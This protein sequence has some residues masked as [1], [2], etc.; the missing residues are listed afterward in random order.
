MALSLEGKATEG[1]GGGYTEWIISVV[2][3][4]IAKSLEKLFHYLSLSCYGFIFFSLNLYCISITEWPPENVFIN[5]E[6]VQGLF[7]IYLFHTASESHLVWQLVNWKV[8][9]ATLK[10]S[11][12]YWWLMSWGREPR[13]RS[14]NEKK[15]TSTVISELNSLRLLT[16]GANKVMLCHT[17]STTVSLQSSREI[18]LCSFHYSLR[19]SALIFESNFLAVVVKIDFLHAW[20]CHCCKAFIVHSMCV[21][22][23]RHHNKKYWSPQNK[24]WNGQI[25]SKVGSNNGNCVKFVK[26]CYNVKSCNCNGFLSF[27]CKFVFSAGQNRL[28]YASGISPTVNSLNWKY[29]RLFGISLLLFC[30]FLFIFF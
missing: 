29:S 28:V 30:G 27:Q 24:L 21:P 14:Q 8:Y 17:G 10:V 13:T 15:P 4:L 25:V 5:D 11:P 9:C 23:T 7:L 6:E 22:F 20:H 12:G 3:C 18:F 2:F 26:K 16:F 19:T 1:E